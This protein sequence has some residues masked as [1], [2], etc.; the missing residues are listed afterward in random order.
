MVHRFQIYVFFFLAIFNDFTNQKEYLFIDRVV[1]RGSEELKLPLIGFAFLQTSKVLLILI[2]SNS[3]FPQPH[4][5]LSP[6]LSLCQQAEVSS[7]HAT[8]GG[9]GDS[10]E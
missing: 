8:L 1:I 5:P 6:L 4:G 2:E 7:T 3:E 10:E 9:S